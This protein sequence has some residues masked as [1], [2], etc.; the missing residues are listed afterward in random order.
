MQLSFL[1]SSLA[2]KAP[3][4]AFVFPFS[5]QILPEPPLAEDRVF[6]MVTLRQNPKPTPSWKT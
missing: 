1:D 5:S 3:Q 6:E 2:E 4:A